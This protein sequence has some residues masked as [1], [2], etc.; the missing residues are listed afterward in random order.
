MLEKI[1]L[2]MRILH[3]NLNADFESNI[4]ACMLDLQRVGVHKAKAITKSEDA[5]IVKAAELYCKWQNDYNGKGEQ[6]RQAYEN[7]RDAISLCDSYS[8]DITESEDS[9]V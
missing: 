4:D 9:N 2:S 6:F 7:L 3:N 1:K 5:L 8:S